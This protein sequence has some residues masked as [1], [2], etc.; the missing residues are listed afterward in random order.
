[1][2]LFNAAIT[3]PGT[4]LSIGKLVWATARHFRPKS[5]DDLGSLTDHMLEDIGLTRFHVD[6]AGRG[7]PFF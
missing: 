1:M 4:G 6:R 7:L 3:K 2:T 5:R